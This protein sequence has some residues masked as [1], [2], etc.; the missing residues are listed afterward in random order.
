LRPPAAVDGLATS[1]IPAQSSVRDP[2]YGGPGSRPC[3]KAAKESL[4][5][6]QAV[7]RPSE[8][9]SSTEHFVGGE[10]ESVRNVAGTQERVARTQESVAGTQE[11]VAGTQERVARKVRRRVAHG[12]EPTCIEEGGGRNSQLADAAQSCCCADDVPCDLPGG[13]LPAPTP[14]A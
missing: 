12:G 9:V 14:L 11:S 3:Q 10:Q 2:R 4:E 8:S 7:P 1:A 6:S 5:G 13:G